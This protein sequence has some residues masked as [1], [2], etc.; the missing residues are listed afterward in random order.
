MLFV[1]KERL[2]FY[3]FFLPNIRPGGLLQSHI[4]KF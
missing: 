1:Y 3:F 4:G 2:H